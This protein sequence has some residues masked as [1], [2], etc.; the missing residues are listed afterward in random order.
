MGLLQAAHIE[1]CHAVGM[2]HLMI[3]RCAADWTGGGHS[4]TLGSDDAFSGMVYTGLPA[5]Q[6]ATRDDIMSSEEIFA[7]S[8][9]V[10]SGI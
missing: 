2:D 4:T 1:Y 9:V 10:V 7:V 5:A 8:D 6:Y 3:S